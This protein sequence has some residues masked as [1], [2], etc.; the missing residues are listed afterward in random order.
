M[1]RIAI[2]DGMIKID[3]TGFAAGR[4]GYLHPDS[5]CLEKFAASKRK[6]FRSLKSGIDSK[7]RDEIIAAIKRRLDSGMRV[8]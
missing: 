2:R 8:E 4:G 7:H 3:F 6:E 5:T 1:V